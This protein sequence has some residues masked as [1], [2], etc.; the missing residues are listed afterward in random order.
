M[1]KICLTP[2]AALPHAALAQQAAA[3]LP[4]AG[5]NF[6]QMLLG[7]GA[8]LAVL[9]GTLWLLKRLT[10]PKGIA[11]GA[12]RVI[13]GVSVGPRERV[14]LLE[15]ED[16]WLL[17]G[18]APGQVSAVHQMP[19]GSLATAAPGEEGR[20]QDFAARLKQLMERKHA[21]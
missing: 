17:V 18:V 13:A 4:A 20:G 5:I 3:P 19:R 11:A 6:L 7:L 16:T 9:V 2:L 12:L 10:A 8:V 1:R 14:V 15:L 21:G